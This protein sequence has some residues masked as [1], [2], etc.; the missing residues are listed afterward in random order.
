[1]PLGLD[2]IICRCYFLTIMGK[3]DRWDDIWTEKRRLSSG[4]LGSIL[5]RDVI[6]RTTHAGLRRAIPDPKGLR[7]L[8]AG[9]GSGLVSLSMAKKGA[10]VFLIDISAEAVRLSR[11]LFKKE[12]TPETTVQ[13][14][15]FALPFKDDSFDIT[16]N[17]GVIEHFS[18]D[19]QVKCLREMLRVTRPAGWVVVLVPSSRARIYSLAKR[20]ADR[21]G[22]WKPGYEAPISS[23]KEIAPRVPAHLIREFRIGLLAELHFLKYH[24][25]ASRLLWLA[26][27]G[28]IEILS[29]VLFPLNY[30]PGYYLV[31]VF[32]K[33]A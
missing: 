12:H 27:C 13:A 11:S 3:A 5:S 29:L 20:H 10:G 24:F 1:L 31:S 30:L 33:Q 7:I 32:R 19:D 6:Y 16:W 15:I 17:G 23:L 18:P 8:E 25:A 22:L 2:L 26:W 28:L 14:S 21:C 9:S 4:K